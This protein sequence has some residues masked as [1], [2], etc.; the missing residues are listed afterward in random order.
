MTFFANS[1]TDLNT[2]QSDGSTAETTFFTENL[3]TLLWITSTAGF[4]G[5]CIASILRL[6]A[7]RLRCQ[8]LAWDD[9]AI[10]IAMGFYVPFYI[11]VVLALS[12]G[13]GRIEAMTAQ[14]INSKILLVALALSTIR[15]CF[16]KVGNT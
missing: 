4:V 2:S 7:R 8:S 15:L 5:A 3:R 16:A 12:W 10:L 9:Y 14:E 13:A 11:D 6:Y 1:L